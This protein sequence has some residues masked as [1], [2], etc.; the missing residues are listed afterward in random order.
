MLL[1]DIFDALTYG[2]LSALAFADEGGMT[3][4]DKRMLLNHINRGLDELHKRFEL[5]RKSMELPA[6]QVRYVV[7]P[8]DNDLLEILCVM[9]HDPSVTAPQNYEIVQ[10][11]HPKYLNPDIPLCYMTPAPDVLRFNH[12]LK[13]GG[14]TYTVDYKARHPTV[15]VVDFDTVDLSQVEI[16][17]PMA[18]LEALSFYIA[19]RVIA[20]IDN[21]LGN[22]Q[23]GVNYRALYE[24]ACQALEVQGL[25]VDNVVE[26]A[27]R[28]SRNGFV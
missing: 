25:D 26:S 14:I 6:G 23:E 20:P 24:Q 15:V 7:R 21:G 10:V 27:Q 2:E 9:A 16:D 13:D 19:S 22:P 4:R 5:K 1:S 17:L 18:Y 3:N 11:N 28:F 8:E 12:A